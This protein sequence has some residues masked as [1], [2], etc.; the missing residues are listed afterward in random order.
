MK[1]KKAV[2]MIEAYQVFEI[3]KPLDENDKEFYV[4][5][6]KDDLNTLRKNLFLN[7]IPQKTFFVTGQS[8]NGKST[9]LNFIASKLISDRYEIKYLNGRDVFKLDDINIIDIL[10]MI[11]YTIVNDDK[12]LKKEFLADLETMRKKSL[13]KLEEQEEKTKKGS[14]EGGISSS[15]GAKFSLFSLL[16]FDSKIF[17]K[18]R[19]EDQ[20]R[21]TVREL[22][23][24][25]KLELCE[26]INAIIGKYRKL[27]AEKELLLIIDD[28]EKVQNQEQSKSIF[29]DNLTIF[30]NISCTKIL[31]FPVYLSTQYAMFQSASKFSIRI[32]DNPLSDFTNDDSKAKSMEISAENRKKLTQVIRNRLEKQ[33]LIAD[34]AI[35]KAVDCSG[36]NLRSL[37]DIMQRSARNAINLDDDISA[38]EKPIIGAIDIKTAV[39][40]AAELPSLSVMRR[41]KVLKYVLDNNIEP[42]AQDTGTD[43]IDSV[44]DNTV[45]AYFNGNPWYDI[46]PILK[47]SVEVYSKKIESE[48]EKNES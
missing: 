34:D 29:V 13:G 41:I 22:L 47:D 42:A 7:R 31:T 24:L 18:V 23:T 11:G 35:V 1:L 2:N 33:D 30:Q 28:L 8:G 38:N 21:K 5:I 12:T 16:K 44:L 20:T 45:F 17:A 10:L 32:D 48:T 6:Y 40:E 46:N 15:L 37:M 9:A 14:V 3:Q 26:K 39:E 25:E 27:H 4:D 19:L 43:F 36:G